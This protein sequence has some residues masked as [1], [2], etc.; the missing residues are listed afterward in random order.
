MG[1][2]LLRAVLLVGLVATLYVALERSQILAFSS[3]LEG[4]VGLGTA[5]VAGLVAATSS[6]LAVVGGVLLSVSA[7]WAQSHPDATVWQRF[8]PQLSFHVG[9]LFGYFV[10]GGIVG[11][12][13]SVI[14]LSTFGRGTLTLGFSL[15]MVVLGL[16]MLDVLPAKYCTLPVPG[17]W[18]AKLHAMGKSNH[19]VAPFLFGILTFFLPCGFTQSMQLVALGT[20]NFLM[21]G[22]IMLA[23]ALGTLPALL[24]ISA[25]SSTLRGN[26]GRWF[27]GLSGALVLILGLLNVQSGLLLSGLNPLSA[28]EGSRAAATVDPYVTVDD[29]GRQII[30]MYV[31]SHGYEPN[32]F[33]IAPNRETWV[34]AIAKEPVG[35]CASFLTAPS[36]QKETPIAVG[37]NWLGPLT[38]P[39]Q[40]FTLLCSMGM[41]RAD[42]HV[43]RS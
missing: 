22:S 21:G 3:S 27:T 26:A 43:R 11:L 42:V 34:Y 33:T 2:R 7:T 37:G 40:D 8:R 20:G 29:Q 4:A 41:L 24:S 14:G 39:T 16:R 18:R 36:F 30:S 28:L 15:I 19:P 6:C 5:F 13:G 12:A 17:S 31:T 38:N 23:F 10:L 25:L 32:S 35:G 9:R 1:Q